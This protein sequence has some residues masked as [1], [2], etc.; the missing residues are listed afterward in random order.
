MG[1]LNIMSRNPSFNKEDHDN[2]DVTFLK[3]E[4]LAQGAIITGL[5]MVQ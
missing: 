5:D 1:K 2:E 4:W 3:P